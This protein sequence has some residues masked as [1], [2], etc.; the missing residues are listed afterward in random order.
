MKHLPGLACITIC[1]RSLQFAAVATIGVISIRPRSCRQAGAP[2]ANESCPLRD[3]E[4]RLKRPVGNL[5]CGR[6]RGSKSAQAPVFQSVCNDR[7]QDS[8]RSEQRQ[9]IVFLLEGAATIGISVLDN[10]PEIGVVNKLETARRRR[11]RERRHARGIVDSC[12]RRNSLIENAEQSLDDLG[13]RRSSYG[14]TGPRAH[15]ESFVKG[16]GKPMGL[17]ASGQLIDR[18]SAVL[19]PGASSGDRR[20]TGGISRQHLANLT[21]APDQAIEVRQVSLDLRAQA[22]IH[23]SHLRLLAPITGEF[24][25]AT[26]LVAAPIRE[27]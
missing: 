14:M 12:E 13:R 1:N 5:P 2:A 11:F 19:L 4:A 20:C 10:G 3:G 18:Y 9:V 16:P 24:A 8:A 22:F 7:L 15:Q 26:S 6:A 17:T 21:A 25:I 27:L 23:Q